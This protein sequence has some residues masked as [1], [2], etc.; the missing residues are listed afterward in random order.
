MTLK[1]P[2][3]SNGVL[4]KNLYLSCEPGMTSRMTKTEE[5]YA[6]SYTPGSLG[7]WPRIES[8][9]VII[10]PNHRP[11]VDRPTK[12]MKSNDEHALPTSSC[13]TH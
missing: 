3:G 4:V 12:K 1:L 5:S 6:K 7:Y 10:P 9:T 13:V 2:K 8:T 11:Q